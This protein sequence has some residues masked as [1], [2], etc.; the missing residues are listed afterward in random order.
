MTRHACAKCG[1]ELPPPTGRGRPRRFCSSACQRLA[2]MEV[3]RLDAALGDLEGIRRRIVGVQYFGAADHG[4]GGPERLPA[5][6]AAIAAAEARPR[7]LL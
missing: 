7:A 1:A 3:V 4:D 2:A 5:I 6:E